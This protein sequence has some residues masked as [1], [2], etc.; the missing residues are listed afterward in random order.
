MKRLFAAALLCL[1]LSIAALPA[2]TEQPQVRYRGVP[3]LLNHIGVDLPQ[4]G[5]ISAWRVL[6]LF[7]TLHE[8]DV[9][10]EVVR[11]KVSLFPIFHFSHDEASRLRYIFPALWYRNH[12]EMAGYD[13][14]GWGI[15][16]LAW[17]DNTDATGVEMRTRIIIPFYRH[18][19]APTGDIENTEVVDINDWGVFPAFW[20]WRD[21]AFSHLHVFPLMFW[22]PDQ[23]FTLF[24]LIW[25]GDGHF[26]LV[27]LF[28]WYENSYIPS[29]RINP[30]GD[31][32]TQRFQYFL[33]PLYIHFTEDRGESN[34]YSE[35]H[36]LWPIF[37]WGDGPTRFERRIFPLWRRSGESI[38][39]VER[40]SI[41]ALFPIYWQG[42]IHA[43]GQLVRAHDVVFPL[44]FDFRWLTLS[45]LPGQDKTGEIEN[46][47][48]ISFPF[49]IQRSLNGE[50]RDL[51]I[52]W[53]LF[54]GK[55]RPESRNTV[56]GY[57][58]GI[59]LS[60]FTREAN[61]DSVF[62]ILFYGFRRERTGPEVHSR[63]LGIVFSTDRDPEADTARVALLWR[64]FE[65]ERQG[66][67]RGLRLLYLPWQIPLP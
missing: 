46:R 5:A 55:W 14:R 31:E 66:D 18:R 58:L 37:A 12:D 19:E 22:K 64:L 53:P 39:D 52:L 2:Q 26:S 56:F 47:F 17:W 25:S 32:W 21:G 63:T 35:H 15:I 45:E 24:P 7:T 36:A 57:R 20:G 6:I 59:L 23:S 29:E 11:G 43:S 34:H 4:G 67:E 1:I 49:W 54:I 27:P 8:T 33:F 48:R 10:G 62:D 28:G 61:G 38:A 60:G 9:A 44:Y 13:A 65:Y 3:L 16:P 40:T 30:E 41:W 51:S 50:T 42:R